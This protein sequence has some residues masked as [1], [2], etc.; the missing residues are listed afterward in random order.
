MSG[1]RS[2]LWLFEMVKDKMLILDMIA[3]FKI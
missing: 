1:K 3:T 2:K